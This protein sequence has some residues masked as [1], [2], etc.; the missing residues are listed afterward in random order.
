MQKCT[1]RPVRVGDAI[2][3]LENGLSVGHY[4]GY[5]LYS[6]YQPIFCYEDSESLRVTGLEGLVRPFIDDVSI[7]PSLLFQQIAP[8][9]AFLLNA[10]AGRFTFVTLRLR[11]Q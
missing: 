9:D 10:C 11:H 4:K 2:E 3:R 5:T 7:T 1:R 6:A 8:E